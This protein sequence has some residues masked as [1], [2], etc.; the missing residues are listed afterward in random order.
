MNNT[1]AADTIWNP[2]WPGPGEVANAVGA[3]VWRAPCATYASRP[4]SRSSIPGLGGAESAA[5]VA[6]TPDP[7]S[8]NKPREINIFFI[9]AFI[10]GVEVGC[11]VKPP[12]RLSL[13]C[14]CGWLRP[15][16]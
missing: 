4:G 13:Q 2:L 12:D 11:K 16:W 8:A 14:G 3:L 7:R 1:S 9:S 5:R 10:E 15:P 6:T